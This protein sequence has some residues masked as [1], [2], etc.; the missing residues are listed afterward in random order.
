MDIRKSITVRRPLEST[1][2]AFTAEIGRWWPLKQLSF[3]GERAKDLFLEGKAGGRLYER[4]TDGE[5]FTIGTVTHYDAPHRVTFTWKEPNWSGP[6]V[7]DVTF[8]PVQ[9]GTLVELEHRGWEAAQVA[10]AESMHYEQGW[11]FIL[12][13][14][15]DAQQN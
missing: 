14:F 15:S 10:S 8:T 12:R 13:L 9:E 1:F 6:T 11:G 5:E 3:G 2:A 4:F 7:V